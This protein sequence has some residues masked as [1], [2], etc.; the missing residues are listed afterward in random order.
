MCVREYECMCVCV[1]VCVF[2]VPVCV[3]SVFVWGVCMRERRAGGDQKRALDPL[4]LQVVV[5]LGH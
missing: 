1:C 2:S 5:S 3:E 4:E